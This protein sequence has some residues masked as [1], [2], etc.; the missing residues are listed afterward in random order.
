MSSKLW[1]LSEKRGCKHQNYNHLGNSVHIS[2]CSDQHLHN[3]VVPIVGSEVQWSDALMIPGVDGT[4][5]V[6]KN[7]HDIMVATGCCQ[8]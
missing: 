6:E 3:L 1:K 2:K 7:F 5:V 4:L 8:M